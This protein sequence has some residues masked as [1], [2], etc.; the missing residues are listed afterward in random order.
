MSDE[1]LPCRE[2]V[3]HALRAWDDHWSNNDGTTQEMREM[4]MFKAIEAAWQSRA[5]QPLSERLAHA[6]KVMD[7]LYYDLDNA[8]YSI[9]GCEADNHRPATE[10]EYQEYKR[11]WGVGR[12]P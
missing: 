4:A 11:V 1:L 8:V 9:W 12:K 6:E 7:S 5:P 2:T 3:A 10:P